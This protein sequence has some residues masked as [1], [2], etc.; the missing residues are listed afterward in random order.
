MKKNIIHLLSAGSLML[1]LHSCTAIEEVVSTPTNKK[2]TID[3][4][5]KEVT[6]NGIYQKPVVADLVLAKQKSSLTRTYEFVNESDAKDYITAEF[7]MSEG[8]DVIVHPIYEVITTNTN[9]DQKTEITITGYP[10]FY[11]N[12]RNFELKDTG[13]YTIFSYLKAGGEEKPKAAESRTTIVETKKTTKTPQKSTFGITGGV[14]SANQRFGLTDEKE[15][16]DSKLG[17]TLGIFANI[18]LS[19]KAS[20]I[21]GLNFTQ[22]GGNYNEGGVESSININYLEIPL[23]FVF[24]TKPRS[25]LFFGFGPTASFALNGKSKATFNGD[26]FSEDLS[27]GS[28]ENENDLKRAELGFNVLAG[29]RSKKGL[30]LTVNYHLGN[31]IALGEGTFNNRYIGFRLGYEFGSK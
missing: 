26:T 18:G 25:G 14:V 4:Y 5:E 16:S 12:L 15:T 1:L 19:E 11:K 9:G 30:S 31:N 17:L 3:Y 20:F 13:A 27:F 8:C 22:K 29:L 24:Y 2:R 6:K 21:P 7:A 10:A 28:D 23:N